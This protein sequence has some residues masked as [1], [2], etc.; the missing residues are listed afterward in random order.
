MEYGRIPYYGLR[1][2]DF[3][4]DMNIPQPYLPGTPAKN[5]K[6]YWGFSK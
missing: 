5:P 3:V 1:E 4:V 2:K 6:L